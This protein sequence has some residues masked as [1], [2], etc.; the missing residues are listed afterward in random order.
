MDVERRETVE[1][2]MADSDVPPQPIPP[3][4]PQ[5]VIINSVLPLCSGPPLRRT[6]LTITLKVAMPSNVQDGQYVRWTCP[7]EWFI[8][9]VSTTR[10]SVLTRQLLHPRV[11]NLTAKTPNPQPWTVRPRR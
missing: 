7:F 4:S 3:H 6:E 11:P 5:W 1:E 9:L 10:R 2:L 8:I